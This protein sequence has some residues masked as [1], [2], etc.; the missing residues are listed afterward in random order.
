M[1]SSIAPPSTP[2][3]ATAAPAADV[4]QALAELRLEIAH[5]GDRL[6]ALETRAVAPPPGAA[7]LSD[8]LVGAIVAATSAYLGVRPRIRQIGLV[9]GG[10]WAQQGRVSIHAS[11]NLAPHHDD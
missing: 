1:A 2:A 7:E 4:L 11:H 5:L 8:E 3:P 6:T 10:S 9:G